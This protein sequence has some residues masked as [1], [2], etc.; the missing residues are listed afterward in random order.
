MDENLHT[1]VKRL[2]I[3]YQLVD[4]DRDGSMSTLGGNDP[5]SPAGTIASPVD[6]FASSELPRPRSGGITFTFPMKLH[7]MLKATQDDPDDSSIVCWTPEG[8][9]FVI[10]KPRRFTARIL[11]TYFRAGKF[12]SF[13]RQLNAYGFSRINKLSGSAKEHVYFHVLF[14][15][16]STLSII[17]SITRHQTQEQES[18]IIS[19]NAASEAVFKTLSEGQMKENKPF[20]RQDSSG[21]TA[22][23]HTS[24]GFSDSDTT[25]MEED[26]ALDKAAF[27][28]A[29]DTLLGIWSPE[30]EE[31]FP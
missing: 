22:S 26:D 13:Q 27:L 11:P 30:M 5:H 3:K 17:S 19:S 21:V 12:A 16:E 18:E 2:I 10:R 6:S 29:D 4:L 7:V 24:T 1:I 23:T 28:V 14:C 20:Y 9:A 8:T 25:G 15:R 31:L